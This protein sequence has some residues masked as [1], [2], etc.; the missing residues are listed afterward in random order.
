MQK[1]RHDLLLREMQDCNKALRDFTHD[2]LVL[3]SIRVSRYKSSK[4]HEKWEAVQQLAKSLHDVL[5]NSWTCE[6]TERHLA[7]LLLERSETDTF[8]VHFSFTSEP[9]EWRET[10]I[11]I[12]KN[13]E[14]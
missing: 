9:L 11:K 8:D 10:Q 4:D 3:E 12:E 5:E 1:K 13:P 7:Q 14:E 2:H 6:C